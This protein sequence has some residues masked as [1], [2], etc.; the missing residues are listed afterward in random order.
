MT[1]KEVISSSLTHLTM[2]PMINTFM[3]LIPIEITMVIETILLVPTIILLHPTLTTIPTM[4]TT[5]KSQF[6]K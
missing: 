2:H 3:S 1:I 6:L 5:T 4:M